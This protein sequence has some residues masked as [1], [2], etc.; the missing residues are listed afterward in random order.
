VY[1]SVGNYGM[2]FHINTASPGAAVMKNFSIA[3]CWF[4]LPFLQSYLLNHK[5]T[6][7]HKI[8]IFMQV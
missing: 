7:L 5:V 1:E 8:Y 6:P 4:S 2:L 3:Q